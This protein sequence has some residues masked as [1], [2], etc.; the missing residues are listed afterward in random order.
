MNLLQL[1]PSREKTIIEIAN[2][3]AEFKMPYFMAEDTD[4]SRKL[5][6]KFDPS[7]SPHEYITL[8]KNGVIKGI[9]CSGLVWYLFGRIGI[10]L[11]YVSHMSGSKSL[12]LNSVNVPELI[13]H[14]GDLVFKEHGGEINHV[15]IIT[16]LTPKPQVVEAEGWY[17]Y[18]I[19]RDFEDFANVKSNKASQYAGV[20]RLMRDSVSID[21]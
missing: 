11:Q 1:S 19:K 10:I 7:I 21:S 20:R 13:M 12:Y 5:G 2:M 14:T 16:E 6:G 3:F 18:V 15:G 17:G 9:D 8:V 4:A